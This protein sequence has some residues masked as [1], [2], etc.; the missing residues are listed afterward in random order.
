VSGDV[1]FVLIVVGLLG[2]GAIIAW[3]NDARRWAIERGGILRAATITEVQTLLLGE[4]SPSFKAKYRY[5]DDAGVE[6]LGWSSQLGY[7]PT[8]RSTGNQCE[9]R[10]DARRPERSVWIEGTS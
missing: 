4:G 3:R 2:L 1:L 6:H 9:I 10:F 8:L 5:V 7:D